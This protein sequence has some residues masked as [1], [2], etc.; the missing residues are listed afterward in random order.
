MKTKMTSVSASSIEKK[1]EKSNVSDIEFRQSRVVCSTVERLKAYMAMTNSHEHH[2]TTAA[3]IT[4][5]ENNGSFAINVKCFVCNKV[6]Q[7]AAD[8]SSNASLSNFKRHFGIHLTKDKMIL[9][10]E[11]KSVVAFFQTEVYVTGT[12]DDDLLSEN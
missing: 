4:V 10:G 7:L 6:I 5:K 12:A 9:K 2:V 11:Q 8:A 3:D 1:G